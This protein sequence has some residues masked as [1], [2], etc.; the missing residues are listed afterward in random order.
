MPPSVVSAFGVLL[1]FMASFSM[2][3]SVGLHTLTLIQCCCVAGQGSMVS[4]RV[5]AR[6]GQSRLESSWGLP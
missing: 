5:V 1:L 6:T 4:L 3:T 2:K